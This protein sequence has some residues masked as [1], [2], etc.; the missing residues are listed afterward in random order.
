MSAI[1]DASEAR[2]IWTVPT[3][4]RMA[5]QD[6][7]RVHG[8][9]PPALTL[10]CLISVFHVCA[11]LFIAQPH[12]LH[13]SRPLLHTTD[14]RVR[15]YSQLSMLRLTC[16]AQL[17]RAVHAARHTAIHF[18][19]WSASPGASDVRSFATSCFGS[20]T[21]PKVDLVE[22]MVEDGQRLV[23]LEN[24]CHHEL[25]PFVVAL[26]WSRYRK[27]SNA[28]LLHVAGQ[29]LSSPVTVGLRTLMSL[30]WLRQ[31][32][33]CYHGTLTHLTGMADANGGQMR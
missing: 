23:W 30:P 22:R 33:S 26:D 5:P 8:D 10:E 12:E 20:L 11:H 21:E 13:L 18:H 31:S 2:D 24:A 25:V 32:F 29:F 28:Q 9:T 4:S 14:L 3:V 1:V 17:V 7:D 15:D 6:L 27:L 16:P 19:H